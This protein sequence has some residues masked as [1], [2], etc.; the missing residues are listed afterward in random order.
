[1]HCYDC[2]TEDRT[3]P[4]TAVCTRCGAG[5][6]RAHVRSADQPLPGPPDPATGRPTARRLTCTVCHNAERAGRPSGA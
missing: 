6:C 2:L 5:V 4:A 1:M 3:L